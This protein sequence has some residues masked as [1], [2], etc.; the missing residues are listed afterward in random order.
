M[1]MATSTEL[2]Y[3]ID[4]GNNAMVHVLL[5]YILVKN[6]IVVSQLCFGQSINDL[7]VLSIL[8]YQ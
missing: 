3:G 6:F 5:I 7:C 1:K 4:G 2:S 8:Q